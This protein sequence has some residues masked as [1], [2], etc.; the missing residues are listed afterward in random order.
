MCRVKKMSTS[1]IEGVV[2]TIADD[3]LRRNK[4][5][6]PVNLDE[7]RRGAM[8]PGSCCL[9][10]TRHGSIKE[11]AERFERFVEWW[12]KKKKKKCLL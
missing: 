12:K 2:E 8:M 4:L 10:V 1:S 7:V 5:P 6:E 9:C 3:T 11:I